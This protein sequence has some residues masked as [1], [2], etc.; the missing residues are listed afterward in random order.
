LLRALVIA[1]KD[2][3]Q[4]V[5]DRSAIVLAVIAPLGLAAILGQLLPSDGGGETHTYAVVDEDAGPL[6]HVFIDQVLSG[7]DEDPG[8]ELVTADSSEEAV[9]MAREDEIAAAFVIPAGFSDAALAGESAAIELIGNSNARIA[10][11]IAQA[12]AGAFVGQVNA[13]R[14]AAATVDAAGGEPADGPPPTGPAAEPP[15]A[16]REG[17]ATVRELGANTFFAAGMAVFFLFFTA[18]FGVLSL[19]AERREGTLA[20]LLAAPIPPGAILIG[21]ALST[22]VLGA[23]SM[24]ILV[25][26]STLLLG[27]EFGQPLGVAVLILGAVISAMG[28]TSLV[29]GLA[30]TEEQAA[31]FGSILAVTLGILGGTF[32]PLSQGP[33]FLITLSQ[34]TPHYWL[35]RGFAD[36][37]SGGGIGD[38][39]APMAAL[40]TFGAVTGGIALMRARGLVKGP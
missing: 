24:S 33:G 7:F 16:I 5:R 28:L 35:M 32:F 9:R 19:L 34:V 29:A 20:R 11:Q 26:A 27:A 31:G 36:L 23:A 30:Q 1:G 18:Q 37:S 25:I 3:R 21:K 13:Q 2:L 8:T 14:I 39:L 6:A 10:T 22:F 12:V 17:A 4:R 40:V 15:V 38:V